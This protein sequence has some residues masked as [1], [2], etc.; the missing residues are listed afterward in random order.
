MKL[1]SKNEYKSEFIK[2]CDTD[3]NL[4]HEFLYWL[5]KWFKIFKKKA[6]IDLTFHKFKYKNK[7]LTQEEIIDRIIELTDN[8]IEDYDNIFYNE[9][10]YNEL[11]DLWKLVC[12]AMW[13]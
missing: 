1:F 3:W 5:N 4:N 7:I 8:G 11:M 6:C 13:W 9:K 12:P 10:N 2:E